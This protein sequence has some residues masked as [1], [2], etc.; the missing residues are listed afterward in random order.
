MELGLM[1]AILGVVA[2]AGLSGIGSATGVAIAG[3]AASGVLSEEP[4]KFGNTIL[5]VALPGTQGFYGFVI[6]VLMLIYLGAFGTV[7]K[8]IAVTQGL[9][10]LATGFFCGLVQWWSAVYQGKV[11]AAAIS[12]V[13]KNPEHS[14]K[15]VVY[16]VMVETYAV[17]GF[18][19]A[20][21]VLLKGIAPG[22]K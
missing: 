9:A 2:C 10:F 11:C 17:L 14:M 22:L 21:I 18:L 8:T 6:A 12:I 5:L 3:S 7:F 15:G 20:L 4:E 13:A 1:L 16:G 19:T